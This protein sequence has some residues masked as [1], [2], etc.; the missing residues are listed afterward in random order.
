MWGF[1]PL[2]P[3]AFGVRLDRNARRE[4]SGLQRGELEFTPSA[5]RRR[6]AVRPS[7]ATSQMEESRR[8]FF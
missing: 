5:V 4:P 3:A 8:F 1:G 2:A 6:G 7:T